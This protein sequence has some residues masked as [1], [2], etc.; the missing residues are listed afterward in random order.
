MSTLDLTPVAAELFDDIIDGYF[1]L[2][3][4]LRQMMVRRGLRAAMISLSQAPIMDIPGLAPTSPVPLRI[5]EGTAGLIH[6]MQVLVVRQEAH[7]TCSGIGN[8]RWFSRATHHETIFDPLT[9]LAEPAFI[10][11]IGF[12]EGSDETADFG[13]IRF[14]PGSGIAIAKLSAVTSADET[15]LTPWISAQAWRIFDTSKQI[16]AFTSQNDSQCLESLKSDA[17]FG[18]SCDFKGSCKFVLAQPRSEREQAILESL[19]AES[20]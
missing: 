12:F 17:L 6:A 7:M 14:E 16:V 19:Q 8:W 5:L 9:R 4:S 11:G 1:P 13:S 15:D 18:D 2:S 3:E 20:L 10:R